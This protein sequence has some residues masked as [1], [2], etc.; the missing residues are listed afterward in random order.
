MSLPARDPG[1]EW[2]ANPGFSGE[3]P[4]LRFACTQCGRCCTG[5]EGF[6]CFSAEEA[7]ALARHLGLSNSEFLERYTHM[8]SRGRSLTE[9]LTEH[10]HDCVF[11]DRT[12]RPGTA[13][14][15]VYEIRPAQCRTWPF[16]KSNLVSRAA[17][18]RAKRTR[19]GMD[20]GPRYTPVEIR[21]QRDRVDI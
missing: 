1:A 13:F 19:P 20:A 21:I 4:G 6:V 14:C 12:T 16:W 9:K 15:S 8:T 18:E 7:D 2:F 3:E 5:P 10:G 17:W 11:L